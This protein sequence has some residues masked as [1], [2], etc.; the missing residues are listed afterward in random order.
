MSGTQELG[1]TVLCELHVHGTALGDAML[2]QIVCEILG[3]T[4]IHHLGNTVMLR[5]RLLLM[6]MRNAY[7][8][9]SAY[10][11]AYACACAYAYAH[12]YAYAYLACNLFI[13]HEP[14]AHASAHLGEMR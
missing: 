13:G 8:Y 9:A 12:A 4:V 6:L 14:H 3:E 1:N 2:P 10:D 7:A 11:C 5:L